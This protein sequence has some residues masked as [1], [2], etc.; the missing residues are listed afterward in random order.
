MKET[1]STELKFAVLI[2]GDNV[3]PSLLGEILSE[4][5]KHGTINIKRIYGD[6]T[7]SNMKS[8]KELLQQ[9]AVRPF[10]QFRYDKNATDGALIMDAM[11]ILHMQSK[12]VNAFC[13]VSSDGDFYNLA[14]RIR[15]HGLFVMGVGERKTKEVFIRSCNQFI[16]TDDMKPKDG[17]EKTLDNLLIEA[18]FKSQGEEGWVSLAKLGLSIRNIDSSFDSGRYGYSSLLTMIKSYNNIFEIKSDNL[19]PPNHWVKVND[20]VTKHTE[21]LFEGT[22]KQYWDPYG[23]ITHKTGD[24]FFHKDDVPNKGELIRFSQNTKVKFSVSKKPNP[25]ATDSTQRNGRAGNVQFKEC[26]A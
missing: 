11:D 18:Y 7:E 14:I 10:Q 15:E 4:I 26:K 23:F 5:S 13:I 2:D 21:E 1:Y 25:D 19:V 20:T 24:Y 16:L 17:I 22:I 9:Y 3:Q 8:W 6:W 12:P